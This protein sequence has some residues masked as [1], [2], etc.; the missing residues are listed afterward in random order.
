M[1]N[2]IKDHAVKAYKT[3]KNPNLKFWHKVGEISVEIGIIVF[4]VTLSIW[5]HDMSDHNHEQ[6][7]VKVFL[8]GVRKDLKNDVV[9]MHEDIDAFNGAGA[10]YKYITRN[11]PG[12][13]LN[14]DSINKYQNYLSNTTGF[15][16]N[17]GRYQGFKS[18]GKIGN[19]EDD[20]LQND[21]VE[22]YQAAIP[23]ILAS[24]DAY[25]HRKDALFQFFN[26]N[27]KRTGKGT[28][29]RLE[30]LATDEAINICGNL[31][32]VEEINIRYKAAIAK[33]KKIIKEIDADYG[34]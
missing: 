4:A 15:V 3:I 20:T 19:I 11:T 28:N 2:E 23:S 6:K 18:S 33:S 16:G 26:K 17:D 30:I 27:I 34:Q 21:I 29:N 10:T 13:K 24:T 5:V 12:F 9:Q 25:N 22:L 31:T 1:E 7:D 8:L 32:D 14:K